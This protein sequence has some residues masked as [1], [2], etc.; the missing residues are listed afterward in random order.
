MKKSAEQSALILKQAKI[1]V[2]NEVKFEM[3]FEQ[4]PE[5]IAKVA[6]G[7]GLFLESNTQMSKITLY[8]EEEL[9]T[10]ALPELLPKADFFFSK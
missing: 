10:I 3:L 5:G 1:L 2:E 7:T 8:T 4:A 9:K 6:L